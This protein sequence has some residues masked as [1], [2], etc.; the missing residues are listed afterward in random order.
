MRDYFCGWYFKC[1]SE[2]KTLA[3]IPAEHRSRNAASCS[4]QLI[5]DEGAWNIPFPHEQFH[6]QRG[7][8]EILLGDNRFDSSGMELCVRTPALSATGAV[9]FGPLHPIKYD[10]MGPFRYIPFMECRHSVQSMQHRVTGEICINGVRY[11]FQNGIGYI[12]GDRG[13]SF[14]REYLWTQCFFEEGSLMLSVADIPFGGFYFTGIIGV[15]RWRGKETRLATYLGARAV[16]IDRGEVVIRQGNK[17]LTVKLI[18]KHTHPLLAPVGGSMSRT[19]HES[20][21]CRAAY[22]LEKNG[23][24]VFSFESAMASFEYEYSR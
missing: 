1:Q 5:T 10:I 14:P 12:E 9:R 13:Y 7:G 17:T 19:I 8:F 24:T 16:K 4:L 6:R 18:E 21:A 20:A 15:I 3:I 11:C 23:H 2:R 22:Q